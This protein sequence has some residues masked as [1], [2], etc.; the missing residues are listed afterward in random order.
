MAQRRNLPEVKK[1][2]QS[3]EKLLGFQQKIS[4]IRANTLAHGVPDLI[5]QKGGEFIAH[6]PVEHAARLLRVHKVIVDGA[7]LIPALFPPPWRKFR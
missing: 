3:M 5:V 7:R 4:S 1:E 6:E 2:R